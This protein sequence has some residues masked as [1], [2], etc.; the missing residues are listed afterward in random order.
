MRFP[1][2]R[3]VALLS[4]Y[5]ARQW[6]RVALLAA[7][8]VATTALQSLIPQIV[9]AFIDATQSGASPSQLLLAAALY[10]TASLLQR[11]AA[12]GAANVGLNVGLISTNAL[13]ADVLR[14]CLTLDMPFHKRHTPGQLIERIAG[15]VG[16]LGNFF[17]QFTIRIAGNALLVA[18][19]LVLVFREDSR[20]GL[21]LAA[22][23]LLTFAALVS[24][25]SLAVTRWGAA[26]QASAEHYGFIEERISDTEDI[27]ANGGEAYV[28]SGFATLADA[29][30]RTER[31]ARLT[32]QLATVATNA[33]FALGFA[34][35]LGFGA[36]LYTQ[37][38]IT[39]GTV[40]LLAAYARMVFEPLENIREQS[41]D[42]QQATAAIERVD[43]LLRQQPA[44]QDAPSAEQATPPTGALA[45]EFDGVSFRYLEGDDLGSDGG[46]APE[47]LSDVSFQLAPGQVLGLLGRTGS[48]KS[49]IARLLFRLYDPTAGAI[50][51]DG[52]DLRRIPLDTL[53][54][55][56]GMVT[57]DVQLFRAT[58]REN[59]TFFSRRV[60]DARA[61]AVLEELG[62]GNWLSQLPH[63]LD[64]Q[65]DAGGQGLSAGEAQLLALARVYLKDPGVIVLDEASSRLDPATERLLER[66]LDR[67]LTG[68]TCI[69]IAHRLATVRRADDIL[70]LEAGRIV[71]HGPRVTLEA[72]PTSRFAALLR[73][74]LETDLDSHAEEAVIPQEAAR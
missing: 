41:Q 62:M 28:M 60:P 38:V 29:L 2:H 32:A 21:G 7:L 70:I 18:G 67:L 43:A 51:L 34:L 30:L 47:V 4:R 44:V 23:A 33:L 65:L 54:E 56:V 8:V 13:R 64:T 40:Y 22:Y 3:Y 59:L 61:T 20:V 48:G 36:Y 49:T 24:L 39:I 63:G 15:D 16:F 72:D 45:A 37:G 73:T 53:R 10:L 35:A 46:D 50:R 31:S 26:R 55:R 27:R 12:V 71:E 68:R 42:L 69:V 5:L 58:V 57:Q 52:T 25:Q 19:I 6:G 14:H 17:S 9:R 66:A 11:V 74:G 1:L